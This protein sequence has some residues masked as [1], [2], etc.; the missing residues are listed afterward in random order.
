MNDLYLGIHYNEEEFSPSILKALEKA[1]NIGANVL[2]IFNGNKR[3]STLREKINLSNQDAKE[4]K[5]FLKNNNIKLFIHSI[6]ILNYCKDPESPRNRWGI[7]NIVYDINSAQKLGAS[8]VVLHMGSYKTEK[9]NLSY[10]ECISNFIK[11]LI[12]ILKK[13]SKTKIPILLETPVARKFMVCGT[14]ELFA[15]LYSKIPLVYK[16]R[17]K[18]CIDT[19]HIFASGYNISNKN[20]VQDYFDQFDKL[21]GV[22]NI[23]LIHLN[24]SKNEF[25]VR[26]DRHESIG[27]GFIFSKDKES[28]VYIL[29]Y[30][31]KRK[32]PLVLETGKTNYVRE[33]KLL[34]SLV[35]N[36]RGGSKKKDLKPLLLKIFNAILDYYENTYNAK[37][38]KNKYRIESYKKAI[39]V[40]NN[41]NRPIYN[42]SN[43]QDLPYIGKGFIEKINS[44]SKTGTLN[45]YENIKKNNRSVVID[46]IK[47]FKN[48]WGVGDILAKKIVNKKIYNIKMLKDAINKGDLVLTRQQ[49]I[50]LKYYDDLNEKI[51]RNEVKVYTD[52]LKKLFKRINVNIYNAGSYL[53]KKEFCGDIDLIISYDKDYDLVN[54]KKKIYEIMEKESII[55]ETLSSGTE[56]SIYI[57]KIDNYKYYRKMDIAFVKEKYLYFYLLYFGSGRDF[58]KKIR[59]I[60][61]KKGYK[62]NEKGLFDKNNRRINFN[63]KS[64]EEIFKYLGVD[65]V[66]HEDRG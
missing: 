7:D 50:G 57:V 2:Q 62:L 23:K 40:I 58:S 26:I 8:G 45:L 37:N 63:P 52:L 30:C 61:S 65:Y 20:I 33:I 24:D 31:M 35:L 22:S 17:I 11:S 5:L 55:K 9:I 64:E 38:I 13:T 34:K 59:T 16:T 42:S 28:L 44:I 14:T 53:A 54:L 27:K 49:M 6:L 47:L 15:K 51:P 48:I 43:V 10:E 3:L 18:F 46:A 39:K 36:M 21:I 60:A 1:K 66:E 19:Q 32:I 29:L 25:D 12:I 4:I 56:K 41:F